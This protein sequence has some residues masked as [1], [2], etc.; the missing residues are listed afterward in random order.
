MP[1]DY[2]AIKQKLMMDSVSLDDSDNTRN[3]IAALVPM[4][5][6]VLTGNVSEGAQLGIKSY[7]TLEDQRQKSR[8]KLLDYLAK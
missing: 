4:A 5:A 2:E 7:Q 8:S 6:G 3:A 1:V